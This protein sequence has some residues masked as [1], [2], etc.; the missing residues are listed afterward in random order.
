MKVKFQY[1]KPCK[2][3]LITWRFR[4]KQAY[5]LR[6]GFRRVEYRKLSSV[7]SAC[8]FVGSEQ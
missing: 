5:D 7:L 8:A 2:E 3:L 4:K 1:I 6:I